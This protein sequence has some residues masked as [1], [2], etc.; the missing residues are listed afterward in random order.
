[1]LTGGQAPAFA[2][3]KIAAGL[4]LIG[5]CFALPAAAAPSGVTRPTRLTAGPSDQMLGVLGPGGR[6]FYVDNEA[7]PLSLKSLE[8][9]TGAAGVLLDDAADSTAPRP[10]RD[11]KHL[12]Y[13][14]YQTNA[15]GQLCVR[16]FDGKDR[17]GPRRCLS[18]E[19]AAV[20][21]ADWLPEGDAIAA[22]VRKTLTGDFELLRY[23]LGGGEPAALLP[24]ATNTGSPAVSPDGKWVAY[25]PLRRIDP[26]VSPTF[27]SAAA[28]ELHLRR[29]DQPSAAPVKLQFELPGVS[30]F[31]AFS[32]DGKQLYFT[33]FLNDTTLD[34]LIDGNDNGVLFRVPFDG[35]N[36]APVEVRR[37]EQLTSAEWNCQYPVPAADRLIATCL[38]EGS[39]HV[40]S[41]PLEGAVPPGWTRERLD[42]QLSATDSR[43]EHLLLLA[44][45]LALEPTAEHAP[46]L[47]RMISLHLALGELESS[48]YYSQALARLGANVPRASLAPLIAEL[49][50]HRRA[51]AALARGELSEKFITEARARLQRLGPL[52]AEPRPALAA[53]AR[54]VAS[55]VHEVLGEREEATSLLLAIDLAKVDDP[56]V[57]DLAGERAG[58]VGR[59]LPT[60]ALLLDVYRALSAHP[61][62]GERERLA[63]ADRFVGWL[64]RGHS[65]AEIGPLLD[66][67]GAAAGLDASSELAFRLDL[68][69]RLQGLTPQAQEAVRAKVFELYKASKGFERRR[70]VVHTTV[71]RAAREDNDFLLYQFADTWVAFV[72]P[73]QAERRPAEDLYRQVVLERAYVERQA[74]KTGDARGRFF[75][76]T[77]Q[78]DAL[79]AHIGFIEQRFAEGHTEAQILEEYRSRYASKP[80]EPAYLFAQAW[81]AARPLPSMADASAQE[82]QVERVRTLLR[83]AGRTLWARFELQQLWGFAAHQRFLKT[84]DRGAAEEAISHYRL[85]LDLSRETPRGRAAVLEDLALLQAAVGNFA[86]ALGAFEERDKLPWVDALDELRHRL[87]KARAYF[88]VE[89]R[90]DALRELEGAQQLL[91][92]HPELGRFKPL[93]L[94]RAA[95]YSLEARRFG[96]SLARYQALLALTESAPAS[97]ARTRTL[98]T[99][100]LG[101][102]AAS[103]GAAK[104][105]QALGHL[106]AAEPLAAQATA[107][108]TGGA[109]GA[110]LLTLGLRAQAQAQLGKWDPAL[111]AGT[112]RRELL[113]KRAEGR[114]VDEDTLDLAIAE[115][116]LSDWSLRK[117]DAAG[118]RAHLEAAFAHAD[119]WSLSTGTAI[120][121]VMLQLLDAAA[122]LRFERGERFAGSPLDLGKRLREMQAQL[123]KHRNPDWLAAR[124]RIT[125][126]LARLDLELS[127]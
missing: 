121:P 99:T 108:K 14:S 96:D 107:G 110:R 42:D 67:P 76:V 27:A 123:A 109:D 60:R 120:F 97:E 119:A 59:D 58:A 47:L 35:G 34:G 31:P 84:G 126:Q 114:K 66:Q 9:G 80:E 91:D 93:L 26:R 53:F 7:G 43:W 49:I 37:A 25:V 113:L 73:D 22:L 83:A 100:H 4:L 28:R 65:A 101:L 39:L 89:R 95:L 50:G 24:N 33:Q 1:V 48:E 44:R 38:F 29:L 72:K 56:F 111:A 86:I 32:A 79:E 70:S 88:Q 63:Y 117:Q 127:N 16:E 116:Q 46:T 125:A 30:G 61:A 87:E 6:L 85:A 11:G 17:P 5:M 94:D 45:R 62:L 20:Y 23:P 57:L 54:L 102:A 74:G 40:Y 51:E 10:S 71:R 104:P 8:P 78:T 112:A 52:Q 77:L 69:K 103:L 19:G 2:G 55:E 122:T 81:L 105:E 124:E 92:K 36:A 18:N 64:L 68:E 106:D 98:Y 115:A 12:L 21:Q 41:L 118:A 90:K 3:L 82:K 15:S 13:L 75:G